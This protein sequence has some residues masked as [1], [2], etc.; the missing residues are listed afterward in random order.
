MVPQPRKRGCR[1]QPHGDS[2]VT[3]RLLQNRHR[4]WFAHLTQGN[5]GSNANSLNLLVQDDPFENR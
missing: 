4:P 5:G 3:Q 2:F 1:R